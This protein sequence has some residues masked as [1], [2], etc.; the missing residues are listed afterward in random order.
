MFQSRFRRCN[1]PIRGPVHG[2]QYGQPERIPVSKNPGLYSTKVRLPFPRFSGSYIAID[3]FFISLWIWLDLFRTVLGSLYNARSV[4]TSASLSLAHQP[5]LPIPQ[6]RCLWS[7]DSLS[8]RGTQARYL[9]PIDLWSMTWPLVVSVESSTG[10]VP[11][12]INRRLCMRELVEFQNCWCPPSRHI[13]KTT[14]KTCD[15]TFLASL[16]KRLLHKRSVSDFEKREGVLTPEF[17]ARW[18]WAPTA[19]FGSCGLFCPYPVPG[20]GKGNAHPLRIGHKS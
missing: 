2:V 9:A 13:S 7:S 16:P 12:Q 19:P 4:W 6:R 17:F 8:R 18:W 3:C 20:P 5:D 14:L 15:T 11:G 10:S 1:R